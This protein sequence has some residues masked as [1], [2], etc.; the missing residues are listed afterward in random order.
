MDF[1]LLFFRTHFMT[2]TCVLNFFMIVYTAQA[3][4]NSKFFENRRTKHNIKIRR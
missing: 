3:N 4:L 1:F 2:F